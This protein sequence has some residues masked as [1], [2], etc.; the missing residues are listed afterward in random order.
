MEEGGT[1]IRAGIRELLLHLGQDEA[2]AQSTEALL[3]KPVADTRIR[4][5]VILEAER[6]HPAVRYLTQDWWEPALAACGAPA[7]THRGTVRLTSAQIEQAVS[8]GLCEVIP[9]QADDGSFFEWVS[10]ARPK[11]KARVRAVD[12]APPDDQRAG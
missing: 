5:G 10:L 6:T 2:P 11:Q 1:T 7:E 3:L 8:A 9:V 12:S 4:P